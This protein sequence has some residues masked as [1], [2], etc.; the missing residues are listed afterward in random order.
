[1]HDY[2]KM[3]SWESF[4][5][6][7]D[8]VRKQIR[9]ACDYCGR[10]PETVALLP[11]TKTHPIESLEYAVRAG[12]TSV[13]ENRVQELVEKAEKKLPLAIE[14][15]GHL[16]TNKV[17]SAVQYASRIQSVDSIRLAEKIDSVAGSMGK[18]MPVLLQVN[19]GSDPAK[20]GTD[21]SDAARLLEF[22][23]SKT[24]MRVDGFMTI[25]PLSDDRDVA[26]MTFENLRKLRDDLGRMFKVE[27][28]E[29]SMGMSG[30][31]KDAIAAGST[32]IRVGTAL[33]GGR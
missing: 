8:E 16:Q 10:D 3:I 26:K 27:L 4:L 15:I 24:S 9:E 33:F 11:V 29:L 23:L 22:C 7:L 19:A 31:M 2:D 6:N 14:L 30:D 28:P 12:F 17:K 5:Q 21:L 32:M 20:F 13:G 1:M 18:S 25:A